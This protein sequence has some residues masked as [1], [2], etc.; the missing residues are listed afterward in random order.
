MESGLSLF[1]LFSVPNYQPPDVSFP[2]K[3]L[4]P[5]NHWMRKNSVE[6]GCSFAVFAVLDSAKKRKAVT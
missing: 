6:G 1:S 3:S 2:Q 5:T 4:P